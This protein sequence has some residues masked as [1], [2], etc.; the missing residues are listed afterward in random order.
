MIPGELFIKDGEIEL[1]AGRK[2]VTLTVANSGDRP[3]RVGFEEMVMRA[4]LDRAIAGIGDRQRHRLAAGVELDL[5]VLD[6]EFTGDHGRYL[7][8]LRCVM[9][10]LVPAIHALAPS[11]K[12]V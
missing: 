2:T 5:A 8:I 7:A 6:E 3:I 1:N 12:D 4:D 11:K 9:A 10:G